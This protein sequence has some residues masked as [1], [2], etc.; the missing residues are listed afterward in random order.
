MPKQPDS[1]NLQ[2]E[3]S[4]I[5]KLPA[6]TKL[7]KST[8]RPLL[9]TQLLVR[10]TVF[11]TMLLSRGDTPSASNDATVHVFIK[12]FTPKERRENLSNKMGDRILDANAKNV[13]ETNEV[14]RKARL[15]YITKQFEIYDYCRAIA[16]DAKAI[17]CFEAL[18]AKDK[19]F[20]N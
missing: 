7:E 15:K 2:D 13:S 4:G 5:S 10:L 19:N 16:D 18:R 17:E 12:E 8:F 9:S 1:Q 11:S 20:W 14:K 6:T 3:E